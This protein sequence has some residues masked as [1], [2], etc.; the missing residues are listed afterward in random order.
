LNDSA[1]EFYS[2]EMVQEAW[3]KAIADL[4]YPPLPEPEVVDDEEGSGWILESNWQVQ[5][6]SLFKPEV[7]DSREKK[8]AFLRSLF[9][10]EIYHWILIP[11]DSVTSAILVEKALRHI[12]NYQAARIVV[13]I[14]ADAV[15]EEQLAKDFTDLQRKRFE[16]TISKAIEDTKGSH[17]LLWQIIVYALCHLTANQDLL[18]CIDFNDNALIHGEKLLRTYKN[19]SFEDNWPKIVGRASKILKPFL[20]S[21][22]KKKTGPKGGKSCTG[23]TGFTLPSDVKQSFPGLEELKKRENIA[24]KRKNKQK[25]EFNTFELDK[26]A[27]NLNKKVKNFGQFSAGLKGAGIIDNSHEIL[28][29]FYRSR[30]KTF[31]DLQSEKRREKGIIPLNS[32]KWTLS[33]PVEELDVTLAAG[34]GNRLIPGINTYKWSTRFGSEGVKKEV[35]PDLLLVIDSSGS[36]T[37]SKSHLH[38][39]F[40]LSVLAS[41]SAIQTALNAGVKNFCAM[42]FSRSVIDSGWTTDIMRI[43]DSLLKYQGGGTVLPIKKI[44][45]RMEEHAFLYHTPVFLLIFTDFG[46]ANWKST[47]DSLLK[48]DRD[49]VKLFYISSKKPVE[50]LIN[51]KRG[52]IEVFWIKKAVEI[53]KTSISEIR[54]VYEKKKVVSA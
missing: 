30:V 13:N 33:D 47:L 12:S 9:H 24:K 27:R 23:E 3:N 15:I 41:F 36:M 48:A 53:A 40:D 49:T 51:L 11:Y 46:L 16:T 43:E 25:G 21:E 1:S 31:I 10:H 54:R 19:L 39:T 52:G 7:L 18:E 28:R 26:I 42:N 34:F 44:L 20:E 8:I 35:Y 37:R 14:V 6:N 5:V 22:N 17:S 4:M 32:I 45:K 50:N 38:G 29:Y 2:V